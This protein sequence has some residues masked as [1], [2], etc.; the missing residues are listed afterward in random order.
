[1][2]MPPPATHE[3]PPHLLD[4]GTAA[5]RAILREFDVSVDFLES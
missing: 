5:A 2:R 4:D 1:M 3:L